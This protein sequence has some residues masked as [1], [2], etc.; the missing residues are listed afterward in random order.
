MGIFDRLK[1]KAKNSL[2][3]PVTTTKTPQQFGTD[4]TRLHP[5]TQSGS[6][7][8][9]AD[10]KSD[11]PPSVAPPP[12]PVLTPVPLSSAS[13]RQPTIE[14]S[15][16]PLEYTAARPKILQ[17]P[18]QPEF[19]LTPP[20]LSPRVPVV[21]DPVGLGRS[22]SEAF[23]SNVNI[24][25]TLNRKDK[26]PDASMTPEP[27]Q[28]GEAPGT[29]TGFDRAL[30]QVPWDEQFDHPVLAKFKAAVQ[31][32]EDHYRPLSQTSAPSANLK[33]DIQRAVAFAA[34]EKDIRLSAMQFRELLMETMKAYDTKQKA[35]EKQWTGKIAHFA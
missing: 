8:L 22:P 12:S 7:L 9:A 25:A 14:V 3:K 23:K 27:V 19:P 26:E 35:K 30:T 18:P 24:S 2:P 11:I 4:A 29:F 20:N 34:K 28:D 21:T 33:G 6:G 16:V 32:F 1:G 17:D 10:K 15:E 13:T 5:E 31:S